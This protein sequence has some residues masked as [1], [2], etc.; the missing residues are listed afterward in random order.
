MGLFK[1][2]KKVAKFA[3]PVAAAAFGLPAIGA[4]MGGSAA[5][6]ATG[7]AAGGGFLAKNSGSLISGGSSI[8]GGLL[9]N[10]G[11]ASAN[12]AN[13]ANAREQMAFQEQMSSTSYQRG[14]ADMKKAGL[15]PILA[16]KQGGASSPSGAMATS[17]NEWSGAPEAAR[18]IGT[19]V[20]LKQQ[21][22]LNEAQIAQMNSGAALNLEKLSTERAVQAAQ[23][24]TSAL[25]A[26]KAS[27]TAAEEQKTWDTITG[28]LAD[29]QVKMNNSDL[30][31]ALS[32]IDLA[33]Y[34][35]GAYRAARYAEKILGVNAKDASRIVET[36]ATKRPR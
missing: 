5:A 22:L 36:L 31:T 26:A 35:T 15:N 27:Q 9:S 23:Y 32:K 6:G 30:S 10:R 12:R 24:S 13:I 16:Y 7:A 33:I 18:G 1:G 34:N 21:K 3:L 28:I 20:Q 2:L 4:A 19:A 25:N 29:N 8:L 11:Q 14:M 17:Q